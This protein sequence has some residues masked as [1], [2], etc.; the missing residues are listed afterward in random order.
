VIVYL[1]RNRLNGKVY[2]G[3]TKRTLAQRIKEHAR[4][5]SKGDNLLFHRAIR[6]HGLGAFEWK[7]IVELSGENA[8]ETDTDETLDMYE[9]KMI[10]LY[11]SFGP[12]G[13]NL[14]EGGDGV[15]GWSQSVEHREKIRQAHLG[16][17]NFNFGKSWGH[18]G[19]F[20]EVS[21]QKMREAALG[22][23]HNEETKAKIAA[24]QYVAVVQLDMSGNQVATYGSMLE[25]EQAT[26][27]ARQGISR[28]CRFPERSTAG[29]RWHYVDQVKA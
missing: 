9:R 2:V 1:A 21:K 12:A 20:S 15:R 14:T 27:V 22:R 16:E 7:A 23:K 28:A 26:G 3:K 19:P 8:S 25:A 11:K 18:K 5:A 13:Y 4:D 10:A 17:K 24:A 6:K 29:Y